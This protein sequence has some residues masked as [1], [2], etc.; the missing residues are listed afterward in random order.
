MAYDPA[1]IEPKWQ[2]HWEQHHTFAAPN[3]G[4]TDFDPSAPKFYVLDMFPYP[5]GVGLHV[6]HPLG[7]IA[8]DIVARF[9][10][11]QGYNV[12]HPMGFD[13]FGLPAEQYAVETGVHPRVTT[14]KNIANMVRQLKALGMGY[15][16]NR[17]LA[18]TD[19]GYV[20][21][22]QWIFL[23]L[24]HSY[25]DP[26]EQRALP[27]SHL[28]H[29]LEQENYYVGLDG[30]LINSG[31][32]EDLQ[33]LGGVPGTAIVWHEMQPDQQSRLLDAYRLAYLDE[34]NVNWCPEL[35]TVLANEEVTAEG[36]SERGNHP[37]AKRPLRQWMLRITAYAD[38]LIE[39]LEAVD[40]PEPIKALQRNW[41]GK[42]TGAEVDFPLASHAE[43]SPG[44]SENA[45][46][47]QDIITVFTTR[48]DTLFGATY[49]VLAP[50]HP[51]V[52][53]VTTDPQRAAVT[54][55]QNQAAAKSTEDRA[56][57]AKHKSGVFTGG[58]AI[59]P[60][61]QQPIP[62]W[63]ADYVLMGYGTGA[64]MAVPAHD[65]RDFAFAT[66]Y[67]LPILQVVKPKL[68][69]DDVAQTL[70]QTTLGTAYTGD[71]QLVHSAHDD[72]DLNGLSVDDAKDRTLKWLEDSGTGRRKQQTR[73]RDWL[74]SRQRYWGEPFPILHGPN[75]EVRPVDEADLP[76]ALPPMD[77]FKPTPCDA[78]DPSPEPPLGRADDAWKR[79]TLDGV[80]YTRELNT[81]PN[82]AGSCWYYLRYLDPQNDHKIVGDS[83]EEYW[84]GPPSRDDG[85]GPGGVDLYVGGQ[86]HAVLHLLY[87]RFWHKV[88]YDLNHVS[89]PEP[90]GK[91]YAQGYIQAFCYRDARGVAVPA[92][93]VVDE[94][95]RPAAESQGRADATFTHHGETV[96]REFGKMGK[97]LKNA[98]A[99]DEVI[100][101]YGTDTL[102]LYEMYMGPLDQ[103]KVWNTAD[104][105]GVNRFLQR[106]W[107][108][109]VDDELADG[110]T[111]EPSVNRGL[112]ITP[113]LPD[114]ELDRL[115]HATIQRVTADMARLSF[116]TAIAALIELNNALVALEKVPNEVAEALVKM[117]APFA[118]HLAEELW[119]RM[120]YP[121]SVAHAAWPY[122]DASKLVRDSAEIAVQVNGKL[123]GK[124]TVPA[125]ADQSQAE[126]AAKADENVAGQLDGKTI[127]KVIYVPGRLLNFVVG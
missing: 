45:E 65:P 34:V 49:M 89:T 95:G 63:I 125:D 86:E 119:S 18:T 42:S 29:Q 36:R 19:P 116:N 7:Y 111:S 62:I 113:D 27:I 38:R 108:N 93:E 96:T 23:Q 4:D 71:G 25:F 70:E 103:S 41:I 51:L 120:G 83:A 67:A 22:T 80:T 61:N 12:L 122:F 123:R 84:M 6:G 15:D 40:W 28:Q 44:S 1:S 118:P 102:R 73:L 66:T 46:D 114:P 117:L 54:A 78:D 39:D 59:N 50:E 126:I 112:K 121:Q 55:Y 2:A 81:M 20:R 32:G 124:V 14:E 92:A 90:F 105:V 43:T 11:M 101:Q 60:V 109:L 3:P 10:K 106:V 48:P 85:Q 99:P 33:A 35:G 104:I 79:V 82:W 100:A 58:Y 69:H 17:S 64:I 24:Y 47:S 53:V 9:K 21:W 13:A 26:I 30:E 72:L 75:G 31:I 5:S 37:V 94:H 8:T 107:R 56:A 52:E 97:S 115:M 68:G 76:V 98:V 77:D 87:A 57:E 74:F 88:L 110:G 16:W 127:R 91:Y